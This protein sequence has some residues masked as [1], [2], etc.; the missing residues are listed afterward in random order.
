ME[1]IDIN[2]DCLDIVFS[3][4]DIETILAISGTCKRLNS[5]V[6]RQFPKYTKY[7][8]VISSSVEML[9][10]KPIIKI[11]GQ[12]LTK[13]KLVFRGCNFSNYE[14]FEFLNRFIGQHIRVLEICGEICSLPF[15]VLVPIFNR[16]EV[17]DIFDHCNR[18]NCFYYIDLP[19]LC[20]NLKTLIINSRAIRFAP[21]RCKSF[22]RL[23]N[24]EL[25]LTYGRYYENHPFKLIIHQ[26]NQLKTLQLWSRH[27]SDQRRYVE[28]YDLAQ[29]LPNLEKLNIE[30][31]LIRNMS[32]NRIIDLH[33][34][35]MLH[36]LTLFEIT[37][38]ENL[39]D[40]LNGVTALKQLKNLFFHADLDKSELAP[41][42]IQNL[43][44]DISVQLNQLEQF[45]T[46]GIA[47]D[48]KSVINFVENARNLVKIDFLSDVAFQVT[49]E[50][51]KDIVNARKNSIVGIGDQ[52]LKIVLPLIRSNENTIQRITEVGQ[53]FW[54]Q[55]QTF[56]QSFFTIS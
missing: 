39:K 8:C 16:I 49:E 1:L 7:K 25:C 23:E 44:V 32:T 19:C 20:Q 9:K 56:Y 31:N 45:R 30:V 46:V 53:R 27:D 6:K 3:F 10:V 11:I 42:T 5:L 13:L 18:I 50:F 33:P 17:L 12:Y 38:V 48:Y 14:F 37:N 22:K 2:D 26:N 24:L 34:L 40:L 21:N 29:F 41:T 55:L 35:R 28:L 15:Q 51:I 47:W 36:T 4:C 54:V 52:K 43:L